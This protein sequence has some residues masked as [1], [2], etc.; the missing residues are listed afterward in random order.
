MLSSITR[1]RIP[2]P[3]F[4]THTR[5]GGFTLVELLIAMLL[6]ALIVG[7]I[8]T[9][10]ISTQQTY[11]R[12]TAYNNAQEAFRYASHAITR[13]TR[14]A[15]AIAPSGNNSLVLELE[16]DEGGTNRNCLGAVVNAP[17]FNRISVSGDNLVCEVSG[18][19]TILVRDVDTL[20]I[21]YATGNS[22]TYVAS[23]QNA[24]AITDWTT[25]SSIR[26]SIGMAEGYQ[27]TFTASVRAL[28]VPEEVVIRPSG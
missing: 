22:K 14:G 18:V 20:A 17:E 23:Y 2:R 19:E 21:T 1:L 24:A 16:P 8:V 27:V 28:L 3:S 7:G 25:A 15:A 26:I 10:F 12:L 5:P 13:M 9:V 4:R 6:G 11:A